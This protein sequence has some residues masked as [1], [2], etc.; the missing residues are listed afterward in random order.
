M[1]DTRVFAL[2]CI[3]T[4]AIPPQYQVTAFISLPQ[5]TALAVCSVSSGVLCF[6]WW[7]LGNENRNLLWK[8]YGWFSGL[9]C[10]GCCTGAVSYGA[11][12]QFLV[13]FYS[14]TVGPTIS[15][16]SPADIAATLSAATVS[17]RAARA[18]RSVTLPQAQRFLMVFWLTY[19]ITSCC[20]AVSKL[21]VLDRLMI[22]SNQ[23][24]APPS[25]L[26]YFGRCV[27]GSILVGS[28]LGLC[29]NVAAVVFSE[30]AYRSYESA[31]K[32]NSSSFFDQ[33]GLQ[34]KQAQFI[35]AFHLIFETLMLLLVV[36]GLVV[37]GIK[38]ARRFQTALSATDQQ[39]LK[40]RDSQQALTATQQQS[41]IRKLRF[42][43]LATCIILFGS[44]LLRAIYVTMYALA[45]LFND[46]SIECPGFIDRCS[47]C[48]NSYAH[49]NVWL[50]YTPEFFYVVVFV[51][52]PV[53]LLVALWGMT[54]GRTLSIMRSARDIALPHRPTQ[55]ATMSLHHRVG[56]KSPA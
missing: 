31:A 32:S 55:G 23:A 46:G 19:P 54:S 15:F 8:H 33:G 1:S 34:R 49:M 3:P 48:Y 10:F 30:Q 14:S 11:W 47:P 24:D 25:R 7:R 12:S 41:S 16:G 36:I 42:Q 45:G 4:A 27:V 53:A 18:A 40:I 38:S 6:V 37:A 22:F 2:A 56:V 35:G 20:L 21:L 44:F 51:S 13:H 39:L 43:I 26:R 17:R 29:V 9:M 28:A 52:E 50:T 5:I